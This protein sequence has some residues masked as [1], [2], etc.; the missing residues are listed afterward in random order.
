MEGEKPIFISKGTVAVIH[1]YALHRN[2]SVFDDDAD[3]FN[4]D[5]WDGIHPRECEYIPFGRAGACGGQ[6][7]ALADAAYT[8]FQFAQAFENVKSCDDKPWTGRV[9]HTA[10]NVNGCKVGLFGPTEGEKRKKRIEAYAME[11]SHRLA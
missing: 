9:K 11:S 3:D 4:P 10:R 6:P 5:R 2:R 8:L 7:K 1:L